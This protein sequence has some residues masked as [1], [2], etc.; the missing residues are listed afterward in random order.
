[1]RLRLRLRGSDGLDM[2]LPFGFLQRNDAFLNRRG[3]DVHLRGQVPRE[4]HLVTERIDAHGMARTRTVDLGE[5]IGVES[6]EPFPAHDRQPML[7]VGAGLGSVQSADRTGHVDA[8]S[9]RGQ[10]RSGEQVGQGG[11]ASDHH[12]D[13]A[14]PQR[15]AALQLDQLVEHFTREPVRVVDQQY[16]AATFHGQIGHVPR[17]G[18][19]RTGCLGFGGNAERLGQHPRPSRRVERFHRDHSGV[20]ISGPQ[21]G[22]QLAQQHALAGTAISLDT[23]DPLGTCHPRAQFLKG[24]VMTLAVEVETRIGVGLERCTVQAEMRFVHHGYPVRAVPGGR[25]EGGRQRLKL[26]KTPSMPR[27]EATEAGLSHLQASLLRPGLTR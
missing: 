13:S 3:V 8:L 9:H 16:R 7:D 23:Q 26:R 14:Q 18:R 6:R 19:G 20:C 22:E 15:T 24:G 12:R 4:H 21:L 11:I 17:Q 27:P 10:G 5:G 25:P 1:M 2:A